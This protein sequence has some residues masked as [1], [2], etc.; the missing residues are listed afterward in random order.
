MAVTTSWRCGS[1]PGTG[2]SANTSPCDSTSAPEEFRKV[3]DPEPS[4][5]NPG[6]R[7]DPTQDRTARGWPGTRHQRVAVAT[8]TRPIP[9]AG[10]VSDLTGPVCTAPGGR[11]KSA[12]MRAAS[13]AARCRG[14]AACPVLAELV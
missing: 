2:E 1:T 12:M 3:A 13:A 8:S 5:V 11:R 10:L 4:G 14:E 6:G 9:T 7:C